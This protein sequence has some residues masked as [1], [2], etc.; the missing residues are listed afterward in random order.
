[1]ED[2]TRREPTELCA[3]AMKYGADKCPQIGH[4]YTPAYYEMFKDRR[5]DIKKV[6]EFGVGNK[7]IYAAIPNYQMGASLRMWR[8][9]FPNAQV[10]GADIA[11]GAVFKDERLETFY[12]DE[13]KEDQ[14]KDLIRKTGSDIDIFVDDCDHHV[15]MQMNLL[16][17]TMPLLK[18][19]VLYIL[20]DC[21]HI[22]AVMH[23]F[24]QYN[25]FKPILIPNS[26]PLINDGMVVITNK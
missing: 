25:Y 13:T 16:K 18:K 11:R 20:E 2:S 19:D 15:N 9:F 1:M 4:C 6:L 23:E 17:Y 5:N 12:C 24:P 26:R 10:Y 8:D 7:R 3:L 21:G 14:I 22:K